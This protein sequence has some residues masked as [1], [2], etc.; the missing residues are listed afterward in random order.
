MDMGRGKRVLSED[1]VL[2]PIGSPL[3]VKLGEIS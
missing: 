1:A 2:A 3:K